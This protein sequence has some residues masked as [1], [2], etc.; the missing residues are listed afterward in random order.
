MRFTYSGV[1]PL[2]YKE[3][4]AAG[5]ISRNHIIRDHSSDG[6]NNLISL[7]GG[8]LTTHRNSSRDIVEAVYRQRGESAPPCSTASTPL[9]GAPT[10]TLWADLRDR[11]GNTLSSTQLA[12]LI[13]V[14]GEQARSLLALADDDPDLFRPLSDGRPEIRAQVVYAW[15]SEYA[16]TLVDFTRRRTVLAMQTLYGETVLEAICDVLQRYC[17]WDVAACER[18]IV[19]H[20]AYMTANCLPDFATIPDPQTQPLAGQATEAQHV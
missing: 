9:P 12:Y 19:R 16:R 1:R 13:S 4:A 15:Q 3:A 17:G 11:Y 18:G 5:S 7:V 20:R 6:I 2:P 14:Y 10:A 8:K